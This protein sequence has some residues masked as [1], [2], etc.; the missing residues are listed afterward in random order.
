M[1]FCKNCGTS[2]PDGLVFC[3]NCGAAV[4]AAPKQ[5]APNPIPAAPPK[6]QA[7]VATAPPPPAPSYSAPVQQAFPPDTCPVV[8][9]ASYFWLM[10]LFSIPLIGWIACI[11]M[12]CGGTQNRSRKNFAKAVLIWFIVALAVGLICWLLAVLLGGSLA[13][14][15]GGWTYGY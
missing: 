13:N 14:A 3:T 6:P 12:A 11:V 7:P 4:E 10:L 8:S 1:P 15:F 5:S 2:L 9:T